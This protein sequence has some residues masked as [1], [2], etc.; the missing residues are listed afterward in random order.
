MA[1]GVSR[2]DPWIWVTWLSRLLVGEHSCEWAAWFK[3]RYTQYDRIPVDFTK[4]EIAHT[5][6]LNE[7]RD[8]LLAKGQTVYTE[9]QNQFRLRDRATGATLSGKPDLVGISEGR[10]TVYDVKTGQHR[11]SDIAQVMIYMWGLPRGIPLF[12]GMTLEGMVVYQDHEVPVHPD[13]VNEDFIS[14][15]SGSGNL[16]R[17]ISGIGA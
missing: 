7:L 1:T 4:W 15:R 2:P 14:E 9:G 16:N 6:K 11:S 13:A 5:A 10:G 3:A 12:K 8:R 17:W